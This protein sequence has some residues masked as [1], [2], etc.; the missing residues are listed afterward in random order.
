ML[1]PV[2]ELVDK[3]DVPPGP[4]L[5]IGAHLAEEAEA[6]ANHG[7]KPVWWVEAN[8]ALIPK[9]LMRM[10]LYPHNYVVRALC[11]DGIRS[12]TFH[13]ASNGES[14]SMLELGTHAT[15]HPDVKYVDK[16]VIR[17]TTVDIMFHSG[18]IGAASFLNID[19][20]GAE[21]EV[22]RG[23]KSYL[24][25]VNT[26]YCEVNEAELYVGCPLIGEID[27]FLSGL[28]FVLREKRMTRHGWGDACWTVF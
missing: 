25:N 8:Q 12:A 4:V 16:K 26:V 5:H 17:T 13:I 11:S 10:D 9:L 1:I 20:Q 7:F 28:G 21:L 27:A 19:V 14:S 2:S 18:L 15:E 3:L 22:L 24:A 6:Y 23:A